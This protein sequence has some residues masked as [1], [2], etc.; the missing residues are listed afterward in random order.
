MRSQVVEAQ[1]T[2]RPEVLSGIPL[3]LSGWILLI[4]LVAFSRGVFPGE[5]LPDDVASDPV[6]NPPLD[7]SG[8]SILVLHL[9][10]D[11]D[12]EVLHLTLTISPLTT[13]ICAYH[14]WG[15][16]KWGPAT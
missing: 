14:L 5:S 10:D 4:Q 6:P 11:D 8:G 15:S 12:L 7:R 13:S 9:S 2:P 16:G 1:S 3:L